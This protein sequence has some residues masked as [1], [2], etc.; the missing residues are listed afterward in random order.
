MLFVTVCVRSTL[1]LLTVDASAFDG[2]PAQAN[3]ETL[4]ALRRFSFCGVKSVAV[5]TA[6]MVC[7]DTK[8]NSF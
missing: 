7:A 6:G 2:S 5:L 4:V 8:S 1:V 3:V